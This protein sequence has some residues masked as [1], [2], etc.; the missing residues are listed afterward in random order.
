MALLPKNRDYDERLSQHYREWTC[1]LDGALELVCVDVMIS[2]I[3]HQV[4]ELVADT[5]KTF[6]ISARDAAASVE[7]FASAY[8]DVGDG[9]EEELAN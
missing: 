2:R 9:L 5:Y 7:A 4:R 6:G 1:A 8:H 3:A